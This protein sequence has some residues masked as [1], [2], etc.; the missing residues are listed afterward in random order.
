MVATFRHLALATLAA[1]LPALAAEA[2]TSAAPAALVSTADH[3]AQSPEIAIGP[4][5]SVNMIWI[6]EDTA[7]QQH[8]P[9][10]GHS[11]MASTNLFFAR[12]TDGGRTFSRPVAVNGKP[13]EVWG[14]SVSKPRIAVGRNGT[15]HVFYPANDVSPATGKPVA[16]ALY[17]RS[18][19]GGR[20]FEK[21]QRLNSYATTDASHLVHG[22]LSHAHVFGTMA[23]DAKGS[24]YAMWIDTRDMAKEGDAGK[25]F[26]AVSRNDGKSFGKDTE[27]F[28]A[29][30]CP[31][32]Q[33]TAHVDDEQRLWVGSRQV[34]GKFRDSTVAVSTDG[35]RSFSPRQRVVGKRWEIEG[36]P[37][38]PTSIA[39][40]GSNVWATYFTGGE[41]PA[42]VY[43]AQSKDAGKTW[44]APMLVHP[45]ATT[46]DAPVIAHAGAA[47]HLFWHAK[48]GSG[49]RRI[50]TRASTD[51]G[52]SFGPVVELPAPPG[53]T[54]LPAVAARANGSVQIAWQQGTE[55]RSMRWEA[56]AP[57][58]AQAAASPR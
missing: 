35:G 54:Q 3:K 49:A 14:F 24:V 12:S 51:G 32:C 13:G 6:D 10:H 46:S 20:S 15:I 19:D 57:L 41:D 5:D 25:V 44:G 52:A 40:A 21:P 43:L 48:V 28:P 9:S 34:E 30:V 2:P 33:L 45:G 50:Y 26:M 47:L 53:A 56:G 55:V 11:H 16:V 31:C 36:C 22:G 4:D 1:A 27:L 38:K 7:P 23:V 18:T 42:G 39:A 29:D 17:T 37:L 58:A 8:D